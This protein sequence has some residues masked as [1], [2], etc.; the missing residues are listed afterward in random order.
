MIFACAERCCSVV[1]VFFLFPA[2][3]EKKHRRA[4]FLGAPLR[5]SRSFLLPFLLH[6][7][8]EAS[9][10][11]QTLPI[12]VATPPASK[13]NPST[14]KRGP[15]RSKT[16]KYPRSVD[17]NNIS[18]SS[19]SQASSRYGLSF[20]SLFC[21]KCGIIFLFIQIKKKRER[22]K[23]AEITETELFVFSVVFCTKILV[24]QKENVNKKKNAYNFTNSF[25]IISAPVP[26]H[27]HA[28][29]VHEHLKN[30]PHNKPAHLYKR[31]KENDPFN[32]LQQR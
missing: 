24:G 6:T 25:L 14:Q 19:P 23:I 22:E 5:V 11:S 8:M 32:L 28:S 20:S 9:N 31:N 30:L 1:G 10:S 26:H 13:P 16:P 7:A 3:D 27:V 18:H 17:S 21:L 4:Q 15:L 12:P 2:K 29:V